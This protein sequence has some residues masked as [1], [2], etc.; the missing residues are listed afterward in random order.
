[1]KK[2][3][4][5]I[6]N[7]LLLA[8][9]LSPI[10]VARAV[11]SSVNCQFSYESNKLIRGQENTIN[12]TLSNLS[13][14]YWISGVALGIPAN[15]GI[16]I[17]SPMSGT[18]SG[19]NYGPWEINYFPPEALLSFP[20]LSQ[21]YYGY[22]WAVVRPD[23]VNF[24]TGR[25]IIPPQKTENFSLKIFIPK[26]A[27]LGDILIAE[28]AAQVGAYMFGY[29]VNEVKFQVIDE[30]ATSTVAVLPQTGSDSVNF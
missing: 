2:V 26:T 1:M 25:H 17:R 4:V 19:T 22:S 21:S 18:F 8:V 6:L 3:F 27:P 30:V 15:M 13:N 29:Q 23:G 24:I 14:Q 28:G 5:L 20:E 10:S 7:L 16:E 11:K 9:I 12:F